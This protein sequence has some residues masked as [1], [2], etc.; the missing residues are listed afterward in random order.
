MVKRSIIHEPHFWL[1]WSIFLISWALFV[2]ILGIVIFSGNNELSTFYHDAASTG[3][4]LRPPKNQTGTFNYRRWDPQENYRP[5][6]SVNFENFCSENNKLGIFK[7]ALHKVV[8]IRDLKLKYYQYNS[9]KVTAATIPDIFLVP[10]GTTND[11]KAFVKGIMRK[12]TTLANGWRVN[13]I[14][15]GNVSEV[16]VNNFDYQ[17]FNEGDLFFATQSNRAI[18]S[19]RNS[20]VVLRGHVKITIADGSTLESNYVK[21]DV[22]KQHFSVNGVYVLNRGGIIT[23]GKGI[24]VDAQL[25]SV[26]GQHAKFEWKE[27]KCIAKL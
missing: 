16:C 20:D 4:D 19:Y 11:T 26:N 25:K 22:Q 13:D 2:L 24:C 5:I 7:T 14:D 9:S 3:L 10:E 12:L 18:V 8:K 17:V 15:L 23:T 27:Q 21:W 6:C 1:K